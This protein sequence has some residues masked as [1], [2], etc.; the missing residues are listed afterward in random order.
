MKKKLYDKQMQVYDNLNDAKK[1]CDQKAMFV[2]DNGYIYLCC[3]IEAVGTMQKLID[4]MYIIQD[5]K[6]EIN[7]LIEKI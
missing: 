2:I 1:E 3:E 6:D 5:A 4:V 7:E